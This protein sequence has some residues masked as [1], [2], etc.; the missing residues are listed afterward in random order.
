MYNSPTLKAL[1]AQPIVNNDI[2]TVEIPT[3]LQEE[4]NDLKELQQIQQEI[5]YCKRKYDLL[6]E[7]LEQ[8]DGDIDYYYETEDFTE[9]IEY[10]RDCEKWFKDAEYEVIGM[11]NDKEDELV[12]VQNSLHPEYRNITFKMSDKE[13]ND[14]LILE[15]IKKITKNLIEQECRKLELL[16]IHIAETFPDG[17]EKEVLLID[18]FEFNTL[19]RKLA[20]KVLDYKLY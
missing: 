8:I 7:I 5:K 10:F 17:N 2:T 20:M 4:M 13:N 12:F 11:I 16:R 18:M 3:H 9:G 15:N 19:H 6:Q 14:D 1:A